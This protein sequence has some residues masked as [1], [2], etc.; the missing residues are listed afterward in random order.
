MYF[1]GKAIKEQMF[2]D[3][4]QG[5]KLVLNRFRKLVFNLFQKNL[6]NLTAK[7]ETTIILLFVSFR[8]KL[9]PSRLTMLNYFIQYVIEYRI[10]SH[11]LLTTD[12]IGGFIQE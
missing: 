6:T 10:L 4:I 8:T 1:Q 7:P 12:L 2:L 3:E 9:Y 11:F 5:C